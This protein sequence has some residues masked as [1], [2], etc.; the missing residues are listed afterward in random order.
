MTTPSTPRSNSRVD[1]ARGVAVVA[2]RTVAAQVGRQVRVLAAQ[3]PHEYVEAGPE[4]R[5]QSGTGVTDRARG[6]ARQHEVLAQP[7]RRRVA[8]DLLHPPEP[9]GVVDV[10]ELDHLDLEVA[11]QLLEHV[12]LEGHHADRP[13]RG[14][15]ASLAQ[16]RDQ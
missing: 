8:A 6:I 9:H 5:Q 11:T 16:D 7:D 1:L 13:E 2:R 10:D 4:R 3:R 15:E 12:G 14:V